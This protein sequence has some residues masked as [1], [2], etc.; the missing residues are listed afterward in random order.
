VV[1]GGEMNAPARILGQLEN[2]P[3]VDRQAAVFFRFSAENIFAAFGGMKDAFPVNK[4]RIIR[5][6]EVAALRQIDDRIPLGELEITTILRGTIP[7]AF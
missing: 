6:V 1:S 4:K 3:S 7:R 5:E 2:R